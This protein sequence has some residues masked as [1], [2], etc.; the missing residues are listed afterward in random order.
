VHQ[1]LFQIVD[2]GITGFHSF[3]RVGNHNLP[4]GFGKKQVNRDGR[5]MQQ[6]TINFC[7]FHLSTCIVRYYSVRSQDQLD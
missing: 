7:S 1:T 4:V 6:A 5:G 3:D 2:L